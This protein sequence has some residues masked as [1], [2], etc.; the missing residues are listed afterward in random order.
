MNDYKTIKL[1]NFGASTVLAAVGMEPVY[2]SRESVIGYMGI[3]CPKIMAGRIDRNCGSWLRLK[4]RQ[5]KIPKPKYEYDG[6][7]MLVW[8]CASVIP[9]LDAIEGGLA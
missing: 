7:K 9:C 1:R 5:G 3:K 4:A 6:K 2:I 8:Y